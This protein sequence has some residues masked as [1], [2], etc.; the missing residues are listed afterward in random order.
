MKTLIV[1]DGPLRHRNIFNYLGIESYITGRMN[2]DLNLTGTAERPIINS[3][4]QFEEGSVGS[5][6]Y[7]GVNSWFD[8]TDNRFNFDFSLNFNGKDSLTAGQSG[9]EIGGDTGWI[10]FSKSEDISRSIRHSTL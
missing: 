4:L 7:Q 2:F 1:V 3:S 6:S 5:V 9:S 8:Y 10:V